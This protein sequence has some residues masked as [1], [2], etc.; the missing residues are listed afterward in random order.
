MNETEIL[1]LAK[2]N[3]VVCICPST[4]AN[5]GDGIFPLQTFL[6]SG[7]RIAIG[8]DSQVSINPFEELR[9]L[10]YGQRLALR[11]RNIASLDDAHVGQELFNRVLAGGAQAGLQ[12]P[13][14][15]A[16]GAGAD[17]VTLNADDPM[18]VGHDERTLLDALI[19]SGYR[20]P[21]ER[22]MVRGVWQVIDGRHI[23]QQ[24]SRANYA[25][26]VEALQ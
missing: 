4:E 5:L 1:G 15:I 24:Q 16:V 20:L 13:A 7:G 14:G 23:E 11:S 19:F 2:S 9:W 17:F 25:A 22:V 12:V 18:L 8:S 21:I 6:A 3:A 10:E 26:A